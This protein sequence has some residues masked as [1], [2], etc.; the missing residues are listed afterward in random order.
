MFL[1]FIVPIYNTEK[2]IDACLMSLLQ[3]DLSHSDYEII[4][5]NDGS[6]DSSSEILQK[7]RNSV[8]NIRIINQVNLGVSTARNAGLSEA[9]GDYVWFIDSDDLVKS[10][11]LLKLREYIMKGRYDRIII[12]NYSFRTS[13]PCGEMRKNT[14]WEDSVVWRSIFR[15][16]YLVDHN[17]RFNY[18]E[19]VFGED[20][21]F[22]Y[23]I[24]LYDPCT[25]EL[26]E[27]MYF[28]REREQSLSYEDIS[29][30]VKLTKLRSNLIEAQVMKK[31]YE[32]ENPLPGTADRLMSFLWGTL[33]R[34]AELPPDVVAPIMKELR[35]CGLFPYKRPVDCTI[36]KSYQLSRDDFVEKIFDKIYTNLNTWVGYIAM[37]A[38]NKIYSIKQSIQFNTNRD[39]RKGED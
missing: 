11:I 10:N 31:Y 36:K 3:Q 29:L 20:A 15:R 4:C 19:L 33:Y 14:S 17:L 5:V 37:R 6:T 22:M 24:K 21:L 30:E 12:G 13:T 39:C 23:E 1:S 34:M 2:Y 8:D 9:R 32:Q 16:K 7:W 25:I 26:D 38:W 28:H 18:P 27:C 35:E